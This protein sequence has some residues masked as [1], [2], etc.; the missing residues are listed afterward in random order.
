[1]EPDKHKK[2]YGERV[3][4]TPAWLL[5]FVLLVTLVASGCETGGA[6]GQESTVGDGED[7]PVSRTVGSV[8]FAETL[9]DW[10]WA[11]ETET[12][13]CM[14]ERGFEYEPYVPQ[15]MIDGIR[16]LYGENR[17]EVK[18]DVDDYWAPLLPMESSPGS[19]NQEEEILAM[20]H[21]TGFNIFFEPESL[22]PS[23]ADDGDDN[24]NAA[25]VA[26]LGSEE[27]AEYHRAMQGFTV[28]DL[29]SANQPTEEQLENSCSQIGRNRAGPEPLPPT[30]L[31]AVD[32]EKLNTLGDEVHRLVN[33]DPRLDAAEA[34]RVACLADQGVPPDPYGYVLSL[35]R[36]ELERVTGD[37]R[38]T[39]EGQGTEPGM[40]EAFGV[41]RL[42]ELQQEELV[43]A[44]AG[45]ECAMAR[46]QVERELITEYEQRILAENPD[47]AALLDH[48]Q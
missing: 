11:V 41:E 39:I 18:P 35:L 2:P 5:T 1:M 8:G 23:P 40:A 3:P 47:F 15:P 13:R 31:D 24:P 26:A 10:H 21:R 33:T 34:E 25:T 38:G 29:D 46:T 30:Q 48:D 6:K 43:A 17:I 16:A 19:L 32:I 22:R 20:A 37:P 36:S 45:N 42:R 14:A 12:A 28:E 27:A 4:T 44:I 7:P 9:I